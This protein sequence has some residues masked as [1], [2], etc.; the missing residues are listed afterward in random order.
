MFGIH[1]L[2]IKN[3]FINHKTVDKSV[4]NVINY[5]KNR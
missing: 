5:V 3:M 1:N 4:D 2:F